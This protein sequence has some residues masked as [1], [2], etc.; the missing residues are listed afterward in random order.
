MSVNVLTFNDRTKKIVVNETH[1]ITGEIINSEIVLNGDVYKL[2]EVYT[3]RFKQSEYTVF[4]TLKFMQ[5]NIGKIAIIEQ[6]W[7]QNIVGL[8]KYFRT[9]RRVTEDE[10]NSLVS[11][12]ATTSESLDT[13]YN[14]LSDEVIEQ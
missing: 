11:E 12:Y 7:I 3:K 4:E 14:S 9:V 2:N 6:K 13:F 5:D 1:P 8:D 10:Y